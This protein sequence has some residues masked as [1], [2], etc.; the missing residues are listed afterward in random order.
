MLTYNPILEADTFIGFL[1]NVF[2]VTG[3]WG[4]PFIVIVALVA[5]AGALINAPP[6][7]FPVA[8]VVN[9][10]TVSSGLLLPLL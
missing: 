7:P 5:P 8:G 6:T 4:T 1:A 10:Y 9:V 3:V 2:T